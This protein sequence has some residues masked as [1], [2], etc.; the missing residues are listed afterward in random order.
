M[1]ERTST[2]GVSGDQRHPTAIA[3]R[4]AAA[5]LFSERSPSSVTLREIAERAGVNYGLIHH[6]YRNKETLLGEVFADFSV[7]GADLIRDAQNLREAMR[8]LVPPGVTSLYSHMLAWSVLDGAVSE[9]FRV[10][11]AFQHI[12]A[13]IEK[14]QE[15][16]GGDPASSPTDPKVLTVALMAAILGWQFFKPFLWAAGELGDR[17]EDAT[18]AEI[19][20]LLTVLVRAAAGPQ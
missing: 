18:S 8:T 17:D 15:D 11:P 12:R 14:E 3:L 10:S 2:E 4:R 1:G 20:D 19:I 9:Q 7:R 16:A 13:L 6:Y 5:E